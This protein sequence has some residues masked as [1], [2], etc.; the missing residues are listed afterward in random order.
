MIPAAKVAEVLQALTE[1]HGVSPA[2]KTVQE[3]IYAVCES[4]R[5]NVTVSKQFAFKTFAKARTGI[6]EE[7]D[8]P[9]P[10]ILK[11]AN[12]ERKGNNFVL[13]DCEV[14]AKWNERKGVWVRP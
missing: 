9:E 2:T 11:C 7:D 1:L 3:P 10:R 12:Y 14:V 5:K 6:P 8:S 4:A 13:R